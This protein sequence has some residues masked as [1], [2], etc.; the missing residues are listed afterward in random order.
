MFGVLVG[1][2]IQAVRQEEQVP[3]GKGDVEEE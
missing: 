2:C 1:R 3:D